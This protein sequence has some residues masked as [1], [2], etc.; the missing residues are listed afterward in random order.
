MICKRCRQKSLSFEETLA[1]SLPLDRSGRVSSIEQSLQR[2]TREEDVEGFFCNN[3]N[4]PTSSNRRVSVLKLPQILILH[5]KKPSC[6]EKGAED[7]PI[8]T[9]PKEEL[10][11]GPIVSPLSRENNLYDLVGFVLHYGNHISGHYVA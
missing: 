11:L 3:C 9:F 7:K 5:L 6:S 8:V 2:F 1:L 10:N 4:C